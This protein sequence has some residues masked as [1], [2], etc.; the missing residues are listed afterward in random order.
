MP[1]VLNPPRCTHMIS[2][3]VLIVSHI[4]VIPGHGNPQKGRKCLAIVYSMHHYVVINI[5]LALCILITVGN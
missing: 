3:N 5:L 1:N 2:R 4:L